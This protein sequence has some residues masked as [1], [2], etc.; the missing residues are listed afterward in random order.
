VVVSSFNPLC[1]LRL[2]RSH[3]GLRRAY[4]LDPDRSVFRHA[5]LV[6]PLIAPRALHPPASAC[7]PSRVRLWRE[8]GLEVG[9]WTVDDPEQARALEAMGVDYLITNRPARLR[10]ALRSPARR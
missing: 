7:T 10:R 3:P 5:F 9:A 8:A 2:A 4:L 1:L 6:A